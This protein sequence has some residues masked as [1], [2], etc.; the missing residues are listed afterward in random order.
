MP[1]VVQNVVQDLIFNLG[2]S[3]FMVF[4]DTVASLKAGDYSAA[5]DHLT[6]SLW[7]TQTG[8][9][10]LEDVALLRGAAQKVG[11]AC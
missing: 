9:R 2:L 6:A 3:K 1:Q 5:A 4:H 10:A 7:F 11:S 8:S